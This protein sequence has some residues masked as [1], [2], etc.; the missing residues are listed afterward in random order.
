MVLNEVGV[1]GLRKRGTSCAP[2]CESLG[3]PN[4]VILDFEVQR[5]DIK[6][7]E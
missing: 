4:R 1:K 7:A 3:L 6:E 5:N 2:Q